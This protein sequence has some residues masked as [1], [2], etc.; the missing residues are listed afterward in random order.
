MALKSLVGKV[1]K[2]YER[3]AGKLSRQRATRTRLLTH[4][5][6]GSII[7]FLHNK[8]LISEKKR[9]RF[10][11]TE[12][13]NARQAEED[14]VWRRTIMMGE[15][16]QPLEFSGVICYDGNGRQVATTPRTPVRGKHMFMDSSSS[17][18]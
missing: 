13:R 5:G 3:A 10:G 8:S 14:A 18:F 16:C 9:E 4:H 11:R 12:A 1:M 15:R 17:S 7:P 6:N 2:L